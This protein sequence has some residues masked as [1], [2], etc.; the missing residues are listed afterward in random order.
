MPLYSKQIVDG[1]TVLC[2]QLQLD[3]MRLVHVDAHTMEEWR[4]KRVKWQSAPTNSKSYAS[5]CVNMEFASCDVKRRRIAH[6]T[7]R[8][9]HQNS[10]RERESAIPVSIRLARIYAVRT[11]SGNQALARFRHHL[12][13]AKLYRFPN[14]DSH[15]KFT[16]N[17][18]H[19]RHTWHEREERSSIESTRLTQRQQCVLEFV[20]E[21][22]VASHIVADESRNFV[23]TCAL[24]GEQQNNIAHRAKC[25][26]IGISQKQRTVFCRLLW[27]PTWPVSV[28]SSFLNSF[29][30]S[31]ST[32][33]FPSRK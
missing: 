16:T 23:Y 15:V 8:K 7:T 22:A 33:P 21:F 17:E 26:L 24:S 31:R 2:D 20:H 30:F 18:L 4:R 27:I 25:H 6:R 32:F 14:N 11:Y 10:E 12:S 1:V 19:R 3:Y 13:G 29:S 9:A 5:E 28:I